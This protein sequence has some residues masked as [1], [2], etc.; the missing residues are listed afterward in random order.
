MVTHEVY[1]TI[2]SKRGVFRRNNMKA[3]FE[4]R[5]PNAEELRESGTELR[6]KWPLAVAEIRRIRNKGCVVNDES[7]AIT[8]TG[9]EISFVITM[10]VVLGHTN[11]FTIRVG[12][13]TYIH[14]LD[15]AQ[16]DHHNDCLQIKGPLSIYNV[17]EDAWT[18]V[19]RNCVQKILFYAPSNV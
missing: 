2:R 8:Y 1:V 19:A 5:Q 9:E 3:V 14:T 13:V 6:I 17:G 12:D 15:I 11:I 4:M 10:E 16:I 7:N 18:R